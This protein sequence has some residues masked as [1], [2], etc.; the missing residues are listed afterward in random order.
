VLK[1]AACKAN[2][3]EVA[4]TLVDLDRVV[5]LEARGDGSS[6]IHDA[7]CSNSSAFWGRTSN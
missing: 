5:K 2:G 6:P 3:Y 1:P 4:V 7:R